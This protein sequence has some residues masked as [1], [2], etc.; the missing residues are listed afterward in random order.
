M[1]PIFSSRSKRALNRTETFDSTFAMSTTSVSTNGSRPGSSRNYDTGF[2]EWFAAHTTSLRHPDAITTPGASISADDLDPAKAL[3]RSKHSLLS[4][5]KRTISHGKIAP[6]TNQRQEQRPTPFPNFDHAVN[7][8]ASQEGLED[9]KG[10]STDGSD[11]AD[12]NVESPT[13]TGARP[14]EDNKGRRRTSNPFKRW[15]N[16]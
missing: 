11:V 3:H 7:A 4:K 13:D 1:P 2:P 15:R 9:H 8:Q 16:H 5:H 6:E 14:E 12:W 10:S